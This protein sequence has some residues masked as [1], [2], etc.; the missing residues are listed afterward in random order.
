METLWAIKREAHV[1]S[2]RTDEDEYGGARVP[3]LTITFVG[4][5]RR[6]RGRCRVWSPLPH[7][8]GLSQIHNPMPYPPQVN[9]PPPPIMTPILM[10]VPPPPYSFPLPPILAPLVP[11]PPVTQA[12][13][14]V[15][16]VSFDRLVLWG[17][18]PMLL[19]N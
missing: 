16:Q 7:H 12:V 15:A 14:P 19:G 2:S 4:W 18:K 9:F 11:A 10:G 1:L 17:T 8:P 5:R 3:S 13:A 6:A